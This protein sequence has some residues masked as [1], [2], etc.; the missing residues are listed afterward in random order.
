MKCA[1]WLILL[2][3]CTGSPARAQPF[4]PSHLFREGVQFRKEGR[5]QEAYELFRWL[6]DFTRLPRAYAQLGLAEQALGQWLDADQ[7]LKVALAA[8]DDPWIVRH[9][10]DL[11]EA[12]AYV[13]THIGTIELTGTPCAQLT[14][15]GLAVGAL[16]LERP[17]R[18]LAGTIILEA[19]LP[20][21][22]TLVRTLAVVPGKLAH[23]DLELP[24]L[25]Q[26]VAA[27]V[28]EAPGAERPG[29]TARV[30]AHVA[31]QKSPGDRPPL[32]AWGWTLGGIAGLSLAGGIIGLVIRESAAAHWNDNQRCLPGTVQSRQQ[33]C[34][35]Y[36]LT[37]N[38]AEI[39]E[40]V[41]FPVAVA[42]AMASTT[43]LTLDAR[44]HRRIG[45]ARLSL[46][47]SRRGGGIE[48]SV[49]F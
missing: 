1:G 35:A 40:W 20:G 17:L 21:H 27:P 44:Q 38:R 30:A 28:R 47:I 49:D 22:A 45:A 18:L 16:P 33:A 14:V 19:R 48:W 2:F 25:E 5:D 29:G 12:A 26:L 8:V 43:L 42:A 3:L 24:P 46:G 41:T 36:L 37:V 4:D 11:E 9:R 34:D 13:A 32:R 10:G 15:N 6:V 23:E 39:A 7:D 31:P